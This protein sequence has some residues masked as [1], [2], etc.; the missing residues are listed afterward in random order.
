MSVNT[1][2]RLTV[3]YVTKHMVGGFAA[4]AYGTGLAAVRK[5]LLRNSQCQT[6]FLSILQYTLATILKTENTQI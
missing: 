2:S 6:E 1:V 4:T 5:V 3:W